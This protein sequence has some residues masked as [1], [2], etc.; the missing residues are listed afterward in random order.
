MAGQI[1]I[2]E[3]ARLRL[4]MSIEQMRKENK[5]EIAQ[6]D[7][8]IE[9]TRCSAQKKVKGNQFNSFH[10]EFPRL[11]GINVCLKLQLLKLSWRVNMMR[12]LTWSEKSMTSNA[13]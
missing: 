7:E 10:K 3:A 13:N 4:E 1:Q 11:F 12:G 2:L 9:D 6:K 8:E 5:K